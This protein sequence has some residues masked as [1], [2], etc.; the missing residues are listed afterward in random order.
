MHGVLVFIQD[1]NYIS[2]SSYVAESLQ[3]ITTF[4]HVLVSP[5]IELVFFLAAGMVLRFGFGMR[6]MLIT[7][8]DKT[9][10]REDEQRAVW[11]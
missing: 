10:N 5:G 1:L 8:P 11:C 9:L 7:S 2:L 3:A 6:T 4:Q